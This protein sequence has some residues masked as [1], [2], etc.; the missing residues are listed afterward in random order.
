MTQTLEV[1]MQA[2][3]VYVSGTV[4][5]METT[6]TLVEGKWQSIVTR[7]SNEIYHIVLTAVNTVGTSNTIN[8]TLYYGLQLVTDRTQADVANRTAKGFY[9]ASDLNRVGTAVDYVY[10]RF[11]EHG[12]VASISVK[13]DWTMQDIPLPTQMVQYLANVTELRGK[14]VG[15]CG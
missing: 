14:L 12:Y 6:W 4:N 9:N 3:V 8:M 15:Y 1:T 5:G 2:D 10:Q 7:A 13:T 11:V